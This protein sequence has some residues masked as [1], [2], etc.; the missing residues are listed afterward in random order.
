MDF[1]V[2]NHNLWIAACFMS[3]VGLIVTFAVIYFSLYRSS[4]QRFIV[5]ARVQQAQLSSYTAITK[6]RIQ[7]LSAEIESLKN[8][9][10]RIEKGANPKNLAAQGIQDTLPS[11]CRYILYLATPDSSGTTKRPTIELQDP[12]GYELGRVP[13][14]TPWWGKR[15]D[16]TFLKRSCKNQAKI[17]QLEKRLQALQ[18]DPYD[19]WSFWD[20]LYFSTI[21]QTTVGF[22]DILPN[23]TSIRLI[24]V[25][26]VLL[27]YGLIVVLLN[28]VF[29]F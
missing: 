7:T 26:Q 8:I 19:I 18:T 11:G 3:Y 16:E 5:A 23:A 6:R 21:C 22:G 25:S 28:I 2:Q 13:L 17:A 24:I 10:S 1:I 14:V 27:G 29:H 12:E 9:Q 20:F 4:P 15:W